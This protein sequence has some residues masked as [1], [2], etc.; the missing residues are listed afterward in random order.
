MEVN[1][2]FVKEMF[3]RKYNNEVRKVGQLFFPHGLCSVVYE[4]QY[5]DR[6]NVVQ[7]QMVHMHTH[8]GPL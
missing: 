4:Q 1:V 8:Y 2:A 3:C 7:L 6:C 5:Q